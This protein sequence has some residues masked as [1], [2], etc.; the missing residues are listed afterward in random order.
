MDGS[1]ADSLVSVVSD[2]HKWRVMEQGLGENKRSAKDGHKG[3]PSTAGAARAA[4]S[5]CGAGA[6]AS[7]GDQGRPALAWGAGAAT[8]P[9]EQ[10]R[11]PI[12]PAT[13]VAA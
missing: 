1:S 5:A 7:P 12:T 13:S 6:V 2:L 11:R 4:A 8:S 3:E 10:G 9:G